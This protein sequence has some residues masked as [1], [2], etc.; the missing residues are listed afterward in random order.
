MQP[1]VLTKVKK[2]QNFKL[3][4]IGQVPQNLKMSQAEFEKRLLEMGLN[5]GVSITLLHEGPF[6]KDPLA[7]RVANSFTLA[8][9]RMEASAIYLL[10]Y[11]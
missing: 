2:N 3:S 4:E 9:R 5:P 7:V 8:L 6:G 11:S 1:L 10:P